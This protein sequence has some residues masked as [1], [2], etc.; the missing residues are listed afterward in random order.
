LIIVNLWNLHGTHDIGGFVFYPPHDFEVFLP[1][2][3][4]VFDRLS[5]ERGLGE[6]DRLMA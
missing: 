3:D 1:N 5:D 4:G 2:H 6:I